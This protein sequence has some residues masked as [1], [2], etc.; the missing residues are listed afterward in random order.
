VAVSNIDVVMPWLAIDTRWRDTRRYANAV[1]T[2]AEPDPL[3]ETLD[4]PVF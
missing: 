3:T 4:L 2:V 1:V